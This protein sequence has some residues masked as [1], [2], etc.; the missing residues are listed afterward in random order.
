MS[1]TQLVW[2]SLVWMGLAL[3]DL[4]YYGLLTEL[5]LKLHANH[6]HAEQGAEAP[7]SVSSCRP[8]SSGRALVWGQAPDRGI[9]KYIS[10]CDGCDGCDSCV[11]GLRGTAGQGGPFWEEMGR[12]YS[13][14]RK[15]TTG[16]DQG[17]GEK[18]SRR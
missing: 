6:E 7:T 4:T 5:H 15:Q 12:P 8:C 18:G 3:A 9:S 14:C 17:C 16:K 1:V 2:V 10:G 11:P 13:L